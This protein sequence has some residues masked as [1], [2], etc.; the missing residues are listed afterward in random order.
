MSI[1]PLFYYCYHPHRRRINI[2]QALSAVQ[3]LREKL[4]VLAVF[5][6]KPRVATWGLAVVGTRG[7]PAA[8]Y[9]FGER[10]RVSVRLPIFDCRFWIF[11]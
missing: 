7:V 5:V 3:P 8:V 2:L 9:D 11:D 10:Y 1:G 6:K 4:T